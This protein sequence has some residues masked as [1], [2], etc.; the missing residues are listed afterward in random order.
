MSLPASSQHKNTLEKDKKP[1]HHYSGREKFSSAANFCVQSFPFLAIPKFWDIFSLLRMRALQCR[2]GFHWKEWWTFPLCSL[3][4][5][6]VAASCSKRKGK[7]IPSRCEM[8]HRQHLRSSKDSQS[9]L[10]PESR[11]S[12]LWF[13]LICQMREA[14]CLFLN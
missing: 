7:D 2:L 10:Q 12:G 4:W 1:S 11:M 14:A 6:L 8:I 9:I 13:Y 3:L 5:V